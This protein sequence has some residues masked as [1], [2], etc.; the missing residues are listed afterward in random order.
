MDINWK[1]NQLERLKKEL[2]KLRDRTLPVKAGNMAVSHF[3]EN[4]RRGGYQDGEF[5]PW[6]KA[7]RQLRESKKAEDNYGTLLSGR[8]HLMKSIKYTYTPGEGKVTV[9]ND[10]IYARIHNEGGV[11]NR[12]VTP[13]PK[14]KT[15]FW[16]KYFKATGIKREDSREQKEGKAKAA[17]D[18]AEKW[19]RAA[20][21]KE[22]S[23]KQV[24]PQRQFMGKG[25][26]IS[27]K[28]IEM[29][30][31]ELEKVLGKYGK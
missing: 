5:T 6:A 20:L 31:G 7:Q 12:K 27:E 17:G 16:A 26:E 9:L 29:A 22:L 15:F 8:N 14:M 30:R 3:K 21:S 19:K 13:T 24:M 11:I 18:D 2:E 1:I 23:I 10:V 4:F 25:K 28:I